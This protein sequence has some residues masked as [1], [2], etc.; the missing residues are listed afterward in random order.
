M[1]LESGGMTMSVSGNVDHKS[2]YSHSFTEEA[3]QGLNVDTIQTKG[4]PSPFHWPNNRWT[5]NKVL[6][7]SEIS[8]AGSYTS[9]SLCPGSIE[10][11]TLHLP[12]SAIFSQKVSINGPHR[13][14]TI[15]MSVLYIFAALTVR[16]RPRS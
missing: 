7:I 10:F 13:S 8:L 6:D 4:A 12:T 11:I 1:E 14:H 9:M 15:K 3:G 5:G 16:C 2:L